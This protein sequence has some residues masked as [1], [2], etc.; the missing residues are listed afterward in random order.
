ML[1]PSRSAIFSRAAFNETG[2]RSGNVATRVVMLRA[3]LELHRGATPRLQND[4]ISDIILVEKAL[5]L[6][7][8]P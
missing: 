4:I 8:S 6:H 1:V 7:E 3:S 2:R 5:H